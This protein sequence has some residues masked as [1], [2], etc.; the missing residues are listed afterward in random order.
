MASLFL[1]SRADAPVAGEFASLSTETA[2]YANAVTTN[3]LQPT[4]SA[5]V[6][7]AGNPIVVADDPGD[8]VWLY[9]ITTEEH[10]GLASE[11]M[12]EIIK[13]TVSG[14]E[15]TGTVIQQAQ[16]KSD[17]WTTLPAAPTNFAVG[18]KANDQY[19]LIWTE[20]TDT[21][22]L[23]R[24][25][26]IY[27]D[28]TSNPAA[29]QANRIATVPKGT[30]AWKDFLAVLATPGKWGITSI[31]KYGNES[32][33]LY[34]D[35]TT[36]AAGPVRPTRPG[37]LPV[38]TSS[39]WDMTELETRRS[40]MAAAT[41]DYTTMEDGS[42]VWQPET[43]MFYDPDTGHEV[44]RMTSTKG[45]E[46]ATGDDIGFS[47]F[48]ADGE[49]LAIRTKVKITG[50]FSVAAQ[51]GEGAGYRGIFTTDVTGANFRA[52]DGAHRVGDNMFHWCPQIPRICYETGHTGYASGATYDKLYRTAIAANGAATPTAIVTMPNNS[53]H[54]LDKLI[55]A[56][57]MYVVMTNSNSLWP[58]SITTAGV[59]TL[60][61]ATGHSTDRDYGDYG[62]QAN[63]VTLYDDHDSY[64]QGLSTDPW[65]SWN[66]SGQNIWW[67]QQPV[68]TN[69]DGG[70][71]FTG[72]QWVCAI[73]S[74]TGTF[75]ASEPLSFTSGATGVYVSDNGTSMTFIRDSATL[76]ATSD[77]ITGGT[78]GE[79]ATLDTITSQ[80]E[81]GEIWPLSATFA[82]QTTG[83]LKVPFEV[84]DPS[85]AYD[86]N[87]C[88]YMSHVTVDRWGDHY[89][90]NNTQTNLPR[91]GTYA[92]QV[93]AGI[94]DW[95]N[96]AWVVP[97][98]GYGSNYMCWSAFADWSVS[99]DTPHLK[100]DIDV[101]ISNRSGAFTT[102]E[103]L[104]FTG[105]GATGKFLSGDASTMKFFQNGSVV[106]EVGDVIS[107]DTSGQTCDL[108][109]LDLR[110]ILTPE[111]ALCCHTYTD[112][113]SKY[114]V[115]YI[116]TRVN[117]TYDNYT[118]LSRPGQSPDG[119]KATF[120]SD[121]L[122]GVDDYPD[123]YYAVCYYP[124]PPTDL[125]AVTGSGHAVDLKFLPPSYST[126]QW[127]G[128][129]AYAREVKQYRIWRKA[130]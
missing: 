45:L 11:E 121:V 62:L 69:A 59:G 126:R 7:T 87:L 124:S 84:A 81:Y 21:D 17:F 61:D 74:K 53:Y 101:S 70:P 85:G 77:T 31:D 75:T 25:Y 104:T 44:W 76:P 100:N 54:V 46:N 15:V 89:I 112:V 95:T 102:N 3:A 86:A 20:P 123:V 122:N 19:P 60:E 41:W 78:S 73:S 130:G 109:S 8:G 67:R 92:E 55:T 110:Y 57:G 108:D 94:W 36:G 35:T 93:G 80:Y 97:S 26:N 9:G 50:A 128:A 2:T 56:D 16:G 117:A 107:G 1:S 72:D 40:R 66:G 27:Y 43:C 63:P 83:N 49:K 115:C 14:G 91:S 118:N 79:T 65:V 5:S 58:V 120:H 33:I 114:K 18:T 64:M 116:H 71:L 4:F 48:S 68:G 47:Q 88:S 90:F 129:T 23:I 96:Q 113:D 106:P 12:S 29:T 24:A 32:T 98:F 52:V 103:Q 119:T 51:Q 42:F 105:S 99:N 38:R 28:S 6:V 30:A 13:V 127:A 111:D 34:D 39:D 82:G 10:S 125:A 22:G 37:G